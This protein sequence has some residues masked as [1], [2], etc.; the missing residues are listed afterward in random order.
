MSVLRLVW[1][2]LRRTFTPRRL[3][4]ELA[5]ELRVHLDRLV[6]YNRRLGMTPEQAVA[7]ARRRLGTL[8]MRYQ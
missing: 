2:S 5:A 8:P 4:I 3:E 6:A 1:H 7:D